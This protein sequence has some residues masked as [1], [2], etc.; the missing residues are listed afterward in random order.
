MLTNG[1]NSTCITSIVRLYYLVQYLSPAA[2]AS[3]D[4]TYDLANIIIWSA[5]EPCFGIICACLPTLGPI[6]RGRSPE[7]LIGRL[8]GLFNGGSSSS[9][10]GGSPS[11]GFSKRSLGSRNG[12]SRAVTANEDAEK[13]NV[14]EDG[15]IVVEKTYSMT[16]TEQSGGNISDGVMQKPAVGQEA[17]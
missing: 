17:M 16:V 5:I 6:F 11:D 9:K 4:F 15:R 10:V 14:G 1:Y 7:S 8:S 13:G 2:Q 12:S 3:E